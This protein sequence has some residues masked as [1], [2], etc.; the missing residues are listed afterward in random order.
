M[1]NRTHVGDTENKDICE[2]SDDTEPVRLV[3]IFSDIFRI[4]EHRCRIRRPMVV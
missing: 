2:K 4:I 1:R 3:P